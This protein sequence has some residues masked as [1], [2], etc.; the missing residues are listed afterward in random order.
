MPQ[1]ADR[2]QVIVHH[3]GKRPVKCGMPLSG[4][5]CPDHGSKVK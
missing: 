3:A 5:K 2:C 4:G 1:R